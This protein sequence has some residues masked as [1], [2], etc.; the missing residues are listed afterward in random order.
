M[1]TVL[2]GPEILGGKSRVAAVEFRAGAA[3]I[4][5][6]IVRLSDFSGEHP[7]GVHALA[8]SVANSA[9]K[10]FIVT[11]G[12]VSGA[13]GIIRERHVI[14]LDTSTAAVG[15]AVYL[16][17]LGRASLT[18]GTVS[19]VIGQVLTV[20]TVGWVLIAPIVTGTGTAPVPTQ[21]LLFTG[22][23]IGAYPAVVGDFVEYDTTAAGFTVTLPTVGLVANDR[24]G[25]KNVGTSVNALTISGGGV[26]TIE[27]PA[28]PGTYAI[29]GALI[30][31]G[32]CVIYQW[33][34][35]VWRIST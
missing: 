17:D 2:Q 18:T 4:P 8:T 33:N 29:S 9:G 6:D 30:N 19:V 25:F 35:T 28:T 15:D 13:Y 31:A 16:S 1:P 12:Y 11:E 34:G 5:F 22:T 26:I 3:L 24:V 23:K 20:A 21:A 27:V 14:T 10:L 32:T 7:V